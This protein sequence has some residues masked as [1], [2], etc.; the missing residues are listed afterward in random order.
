MILLGLDPG[1]RFTGY[2]I[3]EKVEKNKSLLHIDNGVI[4][5]T[6]KQTL[7]ERLLVIFEKLSEIILK[8]KPQSVAIENIFYAKNVQSALKL[9]HAR[10]A[11]LLV[12]ARHN[13]PVTEYLPNSVKQAVT[14]DGHADKIQIQ[15]MVKILFKLPQVPEENAAD[16]LA[17]AFCHANSKLPIKG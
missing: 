10:G 9:G 11:A 6:D 8:Y 3:I 12:C 17:I 2:G 5:T 13:L 15:K 14:G 16:A 4:I 1:S 7:S